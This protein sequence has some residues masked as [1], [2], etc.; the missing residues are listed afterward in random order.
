MLC[1][2]KATMLTSLT[3]TVLHHITPEGVHSD[4]TVSHRQ[5]QSHTVNPPNAKSKLQSCTKNRGGGG[6]REE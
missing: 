3:V 1:G 6:R 2:S 5:L 4:L